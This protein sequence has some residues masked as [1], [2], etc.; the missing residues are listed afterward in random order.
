[1]SHQ[2]PISYLTRALR[3]HEQVQG[4]EHPETATT[5]HELARLYLNQGKYEQAEPLYQRALRIHEQVQ[6]PEHPETAITVQSYAYLLR[7]MKREREATLL[8]ARFKVKEKKPGSS[9]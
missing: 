3:I 8:E 6:G 2:D 5:L 7:L 1:M 4:P 9:S